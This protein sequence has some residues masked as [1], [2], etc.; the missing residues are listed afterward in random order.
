MIPCFMR[1]R[2]VAIERTLLGAITRTR[3]WPGETDPP[4][5]TAPLTV[6]D[7]ALLLGR[8]SPA[9]PTVHRLLS[10]AAR[11]FVSHPAHYDSDILAQCQVTAMVEIAPGI[12]WEAGTLHDARRI[13]PDTIVNASFGRPVGALIEHPD[14]DG[15]AIMREP[16]QRRGVLSIEP[17]IIHLP[18][19]RGPLAALRRCQLILA[20][21]RAET[22]TD[23]SYGWP[24]A[25]SAMGFAGSAYIW[26]S[27][28]GTMT[29]TTTLNH[30]FWIMLPF[31]ITLVT[32]ILMAYMAVN[33]WTG[34]LL[35]ETIT[36]GKAENERRAHDRQAIMLLAEFKRRG[37]GVTGQPE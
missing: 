13:L 18:V 28:I 37:F 22:L 9:S 15:S 8:G 24:A 21:R 32:G 35:T 10:R 23:A 19:P 26:R 29:A 3:T 30:A 1:A 5:E 11:A 17:D 20:A 12:G 14:I 6:R 2:T 36:R 31:G 4:L 16:R 25:I 27:G 7:V 34:D 33:A